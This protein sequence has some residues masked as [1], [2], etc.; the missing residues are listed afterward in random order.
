LLIRPRF[1]IATLCVLQA[2]DLFL[3]WRLLAGPRLD[4]SEANP[5]ANWVL[6][7]AGWTGL[8]ALKVGCS[9]VVVAVALAL[10]RRRPALASRLTGGLCLGMALVAGYSLTLLLGPARQGEWEVTAQRQFAS[11]LDGHL[12]ALQTFRKWRDKVC[13]ELLSGQVDLEE[14]V[15]RLGR[16]LPNLPPSR[17]LASL[18][19]PD[20]ESLA[21]CLLFH[22]SLLRDRNPT[23]AVRLEDLRR[24]CARTYPDAHLTD[25]SR[26]PF[27]EFPPWSQF[28]AQASAAT[29]H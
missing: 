8:T 19:S 3:T 22:A 1:L 17:T 20:P 12:Q 18:P 28:A 21:A 7:R 15:Q 24:E 16:G 9:L 25:S 6:A 10:S 14:A 11:K 2:V 5:L 27:G 4:V 13:R 26:I 29:L 23:Y